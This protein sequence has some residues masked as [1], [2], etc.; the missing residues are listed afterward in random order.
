MMRS[1]DLHSLV[2]DCTG[3]IGRHI[4]Q[5]STGSQRSIVPK[6]AIRNALWVRGVDLKHHELAQPQITQMTQIEGEKSMK[7][8][9]SVVMGC[10]SVAECEVLHNNALIN[11]PRC[12]WVGEVDHRAVVHALPGRIWY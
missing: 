12:L 11:I 2:A 3:F 4:E 7:S 9:Q 6:S 1:I 8:V 10:I 5:R